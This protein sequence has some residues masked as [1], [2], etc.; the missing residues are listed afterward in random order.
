MPVS[1]P[2]PI[3]P[4]SLAVVAAA[5][6]CMGMTLGGALALGG[7]GRAAPAAAIRQAFA[8]TAPAL[9]PRSTPSFDWALLLPRPPLRLASTG[10]DL[11][12]LT[13]A[14]YY[15]ARGEPAA[16]QE[17]VAQVVLNRTRKA[18]FPK[19]VCGVVFQR[20]GRACQFSFVCD[21]SITTR[22]EAA[23]WTRARKVAGRALGGYQLAAIGG[24]THFHVAGLQAGWGGGLLQVARIGAHVFYDFSRPHAAAHRAT[25]PVLSP[26]MLTLPARAPSTT[27]SPPTGAP[28]A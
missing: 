10:R 11:E 18:G 12:C 25:A 16:G 19:S 28:T 3:A 7:G 13:D 4:R 9:R 15:E 23:A 17:A 20:A 2:S 22:R 5:G 24:A 6:A 27:A 26:A 21:G 8:S 1:A 14:V